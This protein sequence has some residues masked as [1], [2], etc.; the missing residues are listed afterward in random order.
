[1][2]EISIRCEIENEKLGYQGEAK[3]FYEKIV[4]DEVFAKRVRDTNILR[5]AIFIKT[6]GCGVIHYLSYDIQYIEK[7]AKD[8]D[9][10]ETEEE[11]MKN[12]ENIFEKLEKGDTKRLGLCIGEYSESSGTFFHIHDDKIIFSFDMNISQYD[13]RMKS[14]RTQVFL[15][16]EKEIAIQL[17][18][19][20]QYIMKSIYYLVK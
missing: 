11:C 13:E 4:Q 7:M 8:P 14:T 16:F 5:C 17:T 1:M 12:L 19:D 15:P 9:M 10:M 3:D 2:E 20:V 6:P 18:R